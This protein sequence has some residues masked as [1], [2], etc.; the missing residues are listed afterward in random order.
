MKQRSVKFL[1]FTLTILVFLSCSKQEKGTF[2]VNN[3]TEFNTKVSNVDQGNF[4]K[5]VNKFGV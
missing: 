5:L 2:V 1:L 4:I 3:L